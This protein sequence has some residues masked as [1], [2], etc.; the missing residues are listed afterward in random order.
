[1]NKNK[2]LEKRKVKTLGCLI[3]L[4]GVSIFLLNY[5]LSQNNLKSVDKIYSSEDI[6]TELKISVAVSPIFIDERYPGSDWAWA[7]TQPWCT[8]S[9]TEGDPYLLENLEIDAAGSVHG[10]CIIIQFSN[11][12][13]IIRTC[14]LYNA[15]D[16]GIYLYDVANGDIHANYFTNNYFGIQLVFSSYN[17]IVGNTIY[18]NA[19]GTGIVLVD[20]DYN[21][22]EMNF[23][24]NGWH[25]FFFEGSNN[26]AILRNTATKNVHYGIVLNY[27]STLN[28]ISE[29]ILKNQNGANGIIILDRGNNNIITGNT[30][31]DNPRHGISLWDSSFNEFSGNM[32]RNNTLY[33]FDIQNC[34]DSI[35][36]DN[37]VTDNDIGINVDSLSSDNLFYENYFIG[38]G[39]HANDYGTNNDWNS[40]SIGNY[41]DDY[42]GVDANDDGIGDTPYIVPGTA[43]SQD[44]FPIWED[45]DDIAPVITIIFPLPD[46]VFGLD[47]PNYQITIDELNLV[48]IWYTLDG[49][50]TNYTITDLTGTFNHLAWEALS[51]GSLTIRFYAS[52][53]GGNIGSA[54][55]TVEKDISAPII[56]IIFPLPD[57]VFGLDAPNYNISI[58][59]LNLDTFW[60]S[61][62]GGGT[63]YT[64]TSLTGTLNQTAW[65]ALPFGDVTITFYAKDA[66][67]NLAS[68]EVTVEKKEPTVPPFIGLDFFITSILILMFSGVAVVVIIAKIHSKKRIIS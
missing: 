55:V 65:A 1:M 56:T 46:S 26:N 31:E 15:L 54:A 41:W 44:N 7:V 49:G 10:I 5:G 33:G 53:I 17:N 51:E 28:D 47:A 35:F 68:A 8:G 4:F 57:S 24:E 61:F 63:I 21:T 2:I 9:G 60:Y 13:F 40:T 38:N 58:D 42:A 34:F 20:S 50:G 45:G 48:T 29:N 18:G 64:I 32:V 25:G 11:A 3:I 19:Q 12:Y 23:V 6:F 62:D 59:E 52:D 14:T 36:S 39:I 66:E 22:I 67:G 43:G 37:I 16:R 30:I 27:G